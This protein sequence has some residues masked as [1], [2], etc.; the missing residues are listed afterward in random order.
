MRAAARTSTLAPLLLALFAAPGFAQG[1]VEELKQ[2]RDK[3]LAEAWYKA[4]DW[5]SDY[6]EAR[7]R[8]KDSGKIIFAY[9]TRSYS[10]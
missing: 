7:K 6:D 8:A 9:F 2:K 3:K 4:N 5:T 10:Y 1:N